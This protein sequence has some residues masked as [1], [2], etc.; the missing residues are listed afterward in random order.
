MPAKP[1]SRDLVEAGAAEASRAI[2]LLLRRPKVVVASVDV[3]DAA[4]LAKRLAPRALVVGFTVSGGHPGRF[5]LATTEAHAHKLAADLVG[6]AKTA[7]DVLSKRALGALT[8][9]GN[10]GASAYLNGVA[11]ALETAC[12]PSVPSVAVDDADKAVALALGAASSIEVA[13]LDAGGVFVDLCF[14]K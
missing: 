11:R 8:E 5:A 3:V 12:V 9:L 2:A 1:T 7:A 13:R 4:T 10:I 14:S 6:P